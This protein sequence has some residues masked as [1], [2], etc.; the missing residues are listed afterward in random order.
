MQNSAFRIATYYTRSTAKVHLH[1]D[2]KVF[3][4]KDYAVQKGTMKIVYHGYP[5]ASTAR[6]ATQPIGYTEIHKYKT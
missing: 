1:V 6:K 3:L 4:L 2:T 5:R